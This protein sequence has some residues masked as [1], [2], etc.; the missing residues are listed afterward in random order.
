M[1]WAGPHIHGVEIKNQE[2]YLCYRCP[3]EEHRG[4]SPGHQCWEEKSPQHLAVKITRDCTL[5]RQRAAGGPHFL[6]EESVHGVTHKLL[7]LSLQGQ[8]LIKCQGHAR[9]K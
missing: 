5:V 3:P 4:L 2:D 8:Q 7:A 9:S 1:E 6:P